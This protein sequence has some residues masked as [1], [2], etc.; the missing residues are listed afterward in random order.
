MDF[1]KIYLYAFC[2]ELYSFRKFIILYFL[3]SSSLINAK[4]KGETPDVLLVSEYNPPYIY[5]NEQGVYI[6]TA[7]NT[8]K[9]IFE[10]A[11]VTYK[12]QTTPWKRALA[13]LQ[14]Q[15]N[16]LIYP[17]ARTPSRESKFK[18]LIPVHTV[19][20]RIY[21]LKDK[22]DLNLSDITSG[23]YSFVCADK[24]VLC[25]ALHS[26]GVPDSSVVKIAH[27]DDKQMIEMIFR[28]RVDF[29]MFSKKGLSHH[30]GKMSYDLSLLAPLV[31]YNYP[32]DE[33]LAG[34]PDFDSEIT[35]KLLRATDIESK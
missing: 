7:V 25:S 13:M 26:F 9:P 20:F 2:M 4:S 19:N 3:L 6:G 33:Y 5:K 17:L 28:G 14:R 15:N 18:W 10:R 23:K 29:M 31:N 35:D 12:M 32:V 30:I 11:G 21:G 27:V 8:L 1:L 16:V 24:T 22:H 34:K